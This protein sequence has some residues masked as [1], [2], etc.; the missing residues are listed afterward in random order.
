MTMHHNQFSAKRSFAC[1]T[2]TK[3]CTNGSRDDLMFT[4]VS[5]VLFVFEELDLDWSSSAEGWQG[6]CSRYCKMTS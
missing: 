2:P 6:T 1:N 3:I 5:G 4:D